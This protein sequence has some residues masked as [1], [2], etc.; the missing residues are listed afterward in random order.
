MT[1]IRSTA[2]IHSVRLPAADSY[3]IDAVIGAAAK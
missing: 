3:Q 2:V 1:T